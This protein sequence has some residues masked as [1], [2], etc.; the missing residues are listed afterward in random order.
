ML[1]RQIYYELKPFLPRGFRFAMRRF[2]AQRKRERFKHIW[3]IDEAAAKIPKQWSG[4]PDSKDFAFVLSHDVEGPEGLANCRQ[5]AELEMSM[6]FRSSFNFIPEGTYRV[7]AELRN[8]LTEHGFEV[9]VH[10]LHHDGK[11]YRD[12]KKFAAKATQINR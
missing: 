3:P 2:W 9:G 6:G 11:L 1:A 7:P 5:L 8:W 4:W 10:D 12:K